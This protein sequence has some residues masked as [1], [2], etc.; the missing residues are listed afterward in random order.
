V[1]LEEHPERLAITG[2]CTR[3]ENRVIDFHRLFMSD[4]AGWVPHVTVDTHHIGSFYALRAT[5]ANP[6]ARSSRRS[7]S[8]GRLRAPL[9]HAVRVQAGLELPCNS[10]YSARRVCIWVC[11]RCRN[12]TATAEGGGCFSGRKPAACIHQIPGFGERHTPERIRSIE[13]ALRRPARLV[14]KRAP[15]RSDLRVATLKLGPGHRAQSG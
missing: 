6:T 5:K 3:P 12:S 11:N 8:L 14:D 7:R 10:A 13:D 2:A 9:A 15:L 4:Q 1:A